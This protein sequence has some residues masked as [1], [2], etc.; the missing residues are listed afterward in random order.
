MNAARRAAAL[1]LTALALLTAPAAAQSALPFGSAGTANPVMSSKDWEAAVAAIGL[2]AQQR[3][4]ADALFND[5]QD[6]MFAA[7][8]RAGDELAKLEPAA[9]DDRSLAA[10]AQAR[11]TLAQS[12]QAEIDG[13][14]AGLAPVGRTAVGVGRPVVARQRGVVGRVVRHGAWRT[15]GSALPSVL[16]CPCDTPP[17]GWRHRC[18]RHS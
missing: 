17:T 2:D 11:R 10:E 8:R 4:V 16:P 14:F 6:R 9:D 3:Q 5:A 1:A 7:K 13:L 15:G 18:G 12:M